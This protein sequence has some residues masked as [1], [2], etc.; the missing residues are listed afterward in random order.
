MVEV[1]EVLRVLVAILIVV[2][3]VICNSSNL[4]AAEKYGSFTFFSDCLLLSAL[5]YMGAS[6]TKQRMK[7]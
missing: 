4:V 2:A 6:E 5:S 7:N 1:V 3:A